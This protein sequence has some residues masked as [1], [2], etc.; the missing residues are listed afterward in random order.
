MPEF[1]HDLYRSVTFVVE[2]LLA[3]QLFL[4]SFKKKPGFNLR[5]ALCVFA[6]ILM[7]TLLFRWTEGTA[8]NHILSFA[9]S[10]FCLFLTHR[11]CF[12]ISWSDAA[13][14]A[15][16]GYNTQFIASIASEMIQRLFSLPR[17]PVDI[18][19]LL[20]VYSLIYYLAGRRIQ[21]GQ[22]LALKKLNI[23]TLLVLVVLIDIIAC[24][25]L[26]PYWMNPSERTL[27][28]CTM[29]PLLICAVLSL[30]LQFTLLTRNTLTNEL[31][32]ARQLIR[33]V[34]TNYQFSKETIDSI[35]QK[36]HDMRHQIRTI[37]SQANMSPEAIREMTE[38]IDI[39]EQL[40]ITGNQ[41]LDTILTEK[42][43]YCQRNNITITCMADGK[44][45]H[46][47][48]DTDIYSLFG[49]ILENSIHAVSGLPEED[50]DILLTVSCKG[51]LISIHSQNAYSGIV[52][53]Q[54]G[55]PVTTSDDAL[56]HGI[57]TRSIQMI[58]S[59]YDGC[60]SFEPGDG[61]FYVDIL[62]PVPEE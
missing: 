30:T 48:S 41:A 24:A 17:I 45:I 4:H 39:Y 49:N 23:Y 16:A 37:G 9:F 59:R 58:T 52:E 38:S 3:C 55:L 62:I 53:M 5:Y 15:T 56:N 1:M 7:T 19:I 14:C 11:V 47:M 32:V 29:L 35:N 50:R 12:T 51:N 42:A 54:D 57:G 2:L 26:R 21:P 10:L 60:V 27:I 8:F 6:M 46:F 31:I 13:F 18:P 20:I 36:C 44:A 40:Y 61:I 22:N 28:I 33:K 25:S 34:E 43:L